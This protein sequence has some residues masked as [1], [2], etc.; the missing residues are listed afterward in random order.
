[1]F[2]YLA[3]VFDSNKQ[4]CLTGNKSWTTCNNQ[5]VLS[6]Q[7]LKKKKRVAIMMGMILQFAP[8]HSTSGRCLSALAIFIY[9]ICLVVLTRD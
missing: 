5:C 2:S 1:M 7:N 3:P 6:E 8:A 4:K 9:D